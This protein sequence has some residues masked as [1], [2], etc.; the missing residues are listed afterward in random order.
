[1]SPNPNTDPDG[2]FVQR[3]NSL[4]LS[5][6]TQVRGAGPTTYFDKEMATCDNTP[7]SPYANYFYCAWSVLNPQN[8]T[9][10][11]N[12]STDSCAT[13]S[14]PIIL[15]NGFGQGT[16]VQTG[17]DGEVYVCWAYYST[18]SVPGDSI[19]FA[20]STNGGVNFTT[21]SGFPYSGIRILGPNPIFHN[22]RVNDFPSMAIDK[23]CGTNRGRIYIA[24][25]TKENGN[26]KAIIQVR[27]SSNGG[28]SWSSPVTVSISNGR[29]NWF[30]WISAD[31]ATGVVSVAYLSIDTTLG[32]RTNTYV[33]YSLDGGSSFTNM[34]VSDTSHIT[35][36]IPGFNGGY[37]G[38]YIGLASFG[39]KAYVGWPD[40]RNGTWQNYISCIT[41]DVPIL[42]S[43]SSNLNVNGPIA[44]TSK[45]S[46]VTYSAV[47]S[48]NIPAT[49]TFSVHDGVDLTLVAG[50]S[51]TILPG[52]S[53]DQGATLTANISSVSSCSNTKS[54]TLMDN[55]I[56][57][58]YD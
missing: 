2:Y 24:Y 37:A 30:P 20:Y 39:G 43:S 38:D 56:S 54:E 12:R 57:N 33:A 40:N 16:N 41:F 51:I 42:F 55:S 8:P 45:R 21:T 47:N 32:Y 52:F 35:A 48:I 17:P 18:G 26:G 13:F 10:K 36:P 27:N 46:E 7:S 9:V 44:F 31:D 5:W 34:K 11:F 1:M 4:G 19:G 23:S 15:K 58:S 3:T 14:T 22:T 50:S 49:N 25:P 29:Q 6:H 53:I 28:I